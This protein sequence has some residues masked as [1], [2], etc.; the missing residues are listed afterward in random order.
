MTIHEEMFIED[1]PSEKG[2]SKKVAHSCT[3]RKKPQ[4]HDLPCSSDHDFR[5][6]TLDN[7]R[8]E[9]ID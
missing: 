8:T 1:N 4:Y 3:L 5:L 7:M 9:S 6:K 2:G